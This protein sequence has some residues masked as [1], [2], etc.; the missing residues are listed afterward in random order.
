MDLITPSEL[1]SAQSIVLLLGIKDSDSPLS[2]VDGLIVQKIMEAAWEPVEKIKETV[3]DYRDPVFDL[4]HRGVDKPAF[5]IEGSIKQWYKDG[6]LHRTKGPAC[7]WF[8]GETMVYE[9]WQNGTCLR[10]TNRTKRIRRKKRKE[11][12]DEDECIYFTVYEYSTGCCM[13]TVGPILNTNVMCL[14]DSVYNRFN[15]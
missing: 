7:I 15:D 10:T 2:I 11:E 5:S 4:R 1:S 13:Q 9:W 8:K 6:L 3:S 12:D 14:E